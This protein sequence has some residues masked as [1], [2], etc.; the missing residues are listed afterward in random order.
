MDLSLI[1]L[2]SPNLFIT[3]YKLDTE[4]MISKLY[5]LKEIDLGN[6]ISNIGGWQN[7]QQLDQFKE[8]LP[9]KDLVKNIIKEN[10]DKKISFDNTGIWGNIS[11]TT[12]YNNIHNHGSTPSQ[13]S[14]VYYLQVF[15]DSGNI[16][17][18]DDLFLNKVEYAPVI[19]D[20]L[21]FPANLLHSVSPN[22]NFKD[23]ISV[24][25]NFLIKNLNETK[26]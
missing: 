23:R 6:K 14:G 9:L 18:H 22:N 10:L 1:P 4:S 21:I 16:I 2:P 24:A 19:G 26:I 7:S 5:Q 3:N 20:L 13:F 8:F 12:H 17:F 15:P 11:S 25:F